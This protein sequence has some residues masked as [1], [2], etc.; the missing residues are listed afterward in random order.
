[1]AS[2]AWQLDSDVA[3]SQKVKWEGGLGGMSGIEE[4]KLGGYMRGMQ[5]RTYVYVFFGR[6]GERK[7]RERGR[8]VWRC[9]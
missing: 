4:G 5:G 1:M 8:S 6:E 9:C 3:E 2:A 7:G